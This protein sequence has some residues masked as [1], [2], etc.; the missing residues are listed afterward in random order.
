MG[1]EFDLPHFDLG[2]PP[3]ILNRAFYAGVAAGAQ[4]LYAKY[5]SAK[6]AYGHGEKAFAEAKKAFRKAKE[7]YYGKPKKAAAKAKTKKTAVKVKPKKR[8]PYKK[9]KV[10]PWFKKKRRS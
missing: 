1:D 3:A 7:A 9:N 5:G 8:L 10:P 6:T 2:A 4:T